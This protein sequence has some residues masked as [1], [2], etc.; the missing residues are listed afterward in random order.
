MP[1]QAPGSAGVPTGGC[2]KKDAPE[3]QE[4]RNSGVPNARSPDKMEFAEPQFRFLEQF[5]V[6]QQA[7]PPSRKLDG[8]SP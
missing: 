8:P 6:V 4:S 2:E 7:D 5:C 1:S 3:R